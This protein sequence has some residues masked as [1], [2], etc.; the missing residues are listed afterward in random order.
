MPRIVMACADCG[1]KGLDLSGWVEVKLVC[2]FSEGINTKPERS[3]LTVQSAS[4]DLDDAR[5]ICH[6]CKHEARVFCR[7]GV[8]TEASVE[9]DA[10]QLRVLLH[11]TLNTRNFR[12]NTW[13]AE[14]DWRPDFEF[15]L[16]AEYPELEGE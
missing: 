16:A 15:T 1:G 6:R 7:N 13:E 5:L 10:Q 14:L 8:I 9:L 11:K 3:P 12:R 2:G 4:F